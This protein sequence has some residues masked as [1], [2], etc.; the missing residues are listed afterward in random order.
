MSVYFCEG[1]GISLWG[2]SQ[3]ELGQPSRFLRCCEIVL[4]VGSDPGKLEVLPC[5]CATVVVSNYKMK[6]VLMT[7]PTYL[8]DSPPSE[9]L[10]SIRQ[11]P[12][13]L[14]FVIPV[15]WCCIKLHLLASPLC[16][17]ANCKIAPAVPAPISQM[18]T[19][20]PISAKVLSQ[21]FAPVSESQSRN[22][23]LPGFLLLLTYSF[24]LV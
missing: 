7:L 3:E 13:L 24:S 5:F 1:F 15:V 9:E 6:E 19:I 23:E 17:S 21:G 18:L 11:H 22:M 20:K 8:A 2:S 4:L 14:L 12:S 10:A 16:S